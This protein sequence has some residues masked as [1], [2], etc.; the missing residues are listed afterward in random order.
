M[1]EEYG[2]T[3][4]SMGREGQMIECG[5]ATYNILVRLVLLSS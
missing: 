2:S 1:E 4:E 5:L 3:P